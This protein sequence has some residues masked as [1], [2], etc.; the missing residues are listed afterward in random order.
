MDYKL[1]KKVKKKL[2]KLTLFIHVKNF[3]SLCQ[4]KF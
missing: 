2:R 4:F 3:Y 1:K